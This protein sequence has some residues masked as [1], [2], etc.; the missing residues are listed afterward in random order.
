MKQYSDIDYG[1]RPASYWED[2][3]ILTALL[4][5]V[6]GQLRVLSRVVRPL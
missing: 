3:D 2:A 5:N 4:R 6:K 1:Q